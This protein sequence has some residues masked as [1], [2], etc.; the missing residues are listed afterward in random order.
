MLLDAGLQL[1]IHGERVEVTVA[2][3]FQ[4]IV[5]RQRGLFQDQFFDLA[6]ETH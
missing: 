3:Y 4:M 2:E 1:D 5:R 6:L